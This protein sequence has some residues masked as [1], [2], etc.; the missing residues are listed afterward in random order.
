MANINDYLITD[1]E[2]YTP[3]I[4]RLVSMMNYA[5]RVTIESVQNL[6]IPQLDYLLDEKANSIGALLLHIASTD[7]FYRILSFEKREL[8]P[9]EDKEWAPASYLGQPGREHIKGNNINF[10]LES[11]ANERNKVLD[12]LKSVN[13]SWLY[14]EMPF[15]N[16]KPANNY[17]IW[18]HTFEDEINHRGQINLIRKRI[19]EDL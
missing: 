6:T 16:G 10:Y 7:Y 19:P 11:L 17:F 13:D 1:I 9:E 8:T 18:F 12:K 4:S 5:R 15:W 2:G 14:E 3:E